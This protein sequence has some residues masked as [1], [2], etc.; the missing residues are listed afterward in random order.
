MRFVLAIAIL[1]AATASQSQV[2]AFTADDLG[3]LAGC[4]ETSTKTARISE[5]WMKPAGGSLMGMSRTVRG[6][7]TVAWEFIRIAAVDGVLAYIAKPHQNKE[8]TIFKLTEASP[9]RV[10]F[11][12]PAHD[13]PQR[14]I[15]R[16]D[17]GDKVHARVEADRDG[18]VSGVDYA[19]RRI[20]CD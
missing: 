8:E 20:R 7:K 2:G 17:G 15:Y 1:A 4:W 10:V 16:K 14:V 5:Q 3:W 11:A 12:N 18:K 13:F 9:L 19:Y 6:D